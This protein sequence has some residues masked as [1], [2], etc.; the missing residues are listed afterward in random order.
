M[1]ETEEQTDYGMCD[2][3]NRVGLV[4]VHEVWDGEERISTRAMCLECEAE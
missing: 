4:V 2:Q 3:C 1:K